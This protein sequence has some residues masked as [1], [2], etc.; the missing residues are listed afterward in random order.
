MTDKELLERLR[1]AYKVYPN[2]SKEIESFISWMYQQYG[3]VLP[4]KKDGTA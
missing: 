1:I 3:I 2:P 4:E